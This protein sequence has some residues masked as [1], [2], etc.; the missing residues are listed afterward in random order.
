MTDH[1]ARGRFI[2]FRKSD[3]SRMCL[4]SGLV[5][6]EDETDFHDFRRLLEAL[7]HFEYHQLLEAL[8]DTYAPFNA[9]AD[10]RP[11]RPMDPDVLFSHFR[12]HH[13]NGPA[14]GLGRRI[15]L[16]DSPGS[17]LR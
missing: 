5:A 16:Q 8:K 12:A 15:A 10:T 3:L 13:E 11:I 4:D 2:P 9:D 6:R 14:R 1:Q 17:R 7:L